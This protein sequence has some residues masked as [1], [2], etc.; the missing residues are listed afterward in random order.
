MVLVPVLSPKAETGAG[1]FAF[2]GRKSMA[3][4][5]WKTWNPIVQ[6]RVKR[7]ERRE[8]F[9]AAAERGVSVSA[10]VR[11]AIRKLIASGSPT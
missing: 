6:I 2:G 9:K 3:T 8:V 7:N 1:L 11:L 5:Q 10:F 4:E